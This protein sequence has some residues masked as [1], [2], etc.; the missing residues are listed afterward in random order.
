V[1]P[2]SG[3]RGTLLVLL[4]LPFLLVR[5]VYFLLL[6]YGDPKFNPVS[7]DV[8]I[9]AGM[10]LLMEIIIVIILLAARAMA[11]PIEGVAGDKR[12]PRVATLI[13]L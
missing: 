1:L 8:R 2:A 11:E 3:K 7:G 10:G 5:V 9:L 6:E 13:G 4:A 12:L